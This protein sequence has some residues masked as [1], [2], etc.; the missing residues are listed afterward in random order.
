MVLGVAP[1]NVYL[2][3]LAAPTAPKKLALRGAIL[4]VAWGVQDDVYAGG[5]A[6]EVRS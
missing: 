2:H 4:D 6:K 5:L 3:D 1:Q